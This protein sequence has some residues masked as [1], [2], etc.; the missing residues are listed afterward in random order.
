M[1]FNDW[2]SRRRVVFIGVIAYVALV[3]LL[4]ISGKR[5]LTKLNAFDLVITVALGSTLSAILLNKAISVSEGV[6]AFGLLILL[7]FAITW[8]AVR[9]PPF[10]SAIKSEPSL[11]LHRG[12]YLD[13]AMRTQPINRAEILSAIRAKGASGIDEIAAVVLETD[14]SLS[15]VGQAMDRLPG[16]F[17]GLRFCWMTAARVLELRRRFQLVRGGIH[18]PLVVI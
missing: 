17:F 2:D 15:V 1:F 11:L 9:W 12:Q 6:M 8:L 5:T 13:R 14:G 16:Q 4:R 18:M 7:Q 10:E 3:L